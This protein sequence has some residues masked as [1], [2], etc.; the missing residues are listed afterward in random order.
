MATEWKEVKIGELGEVV[1]GATPST[2]NK[3]FYGGDIAWITPKDLSNYNE[4]YITRGERNITELG[5]QSCST[6][7]L[8]KNSILFSSRAPIGY[9]AIARN[10]MCTNQGFKSIIANADTDYL[11]LFYLLK[12]NKD[13]IE[14][15]GSGT[16]FKEVSTKVMQSIKLK[17]PCK[18]TQQKIAKILSSLDEKIELNNKMNENLHAQAQAIFKSWFVDFEPF[19]GTMPSDWEE[20]LLEEICTIQN[21][22][23]FKSNDY[24][25]DGCKMVRVT[26]INDCYLENEDYINLPCSFYDDEKYRQFQ[27][28]SFDI[29]LVM[30]G[31]TIGKIGIV[32]EKDLPCL[33]N[34]N[35]WRFR[36]KNNISQPYIYFTV[37]SIN[38]CVCGWSTGSARDFYRKDIFAKAKC[39]LPPCEVLEKFN[40]IQLNLFKKISN[41]LFENIKLAQIRDTLL[42][43]LMSG[44]LE[45]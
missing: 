32:T 28:K 18:Q 14:A 9:I 33:Q 13:K 21:G 17:V 6:R 38:K 34:Q 29:L 30:V 2:K 36:S 3:D 39:M 1:G 12:F 27:L 43:K 45:V 4:R 31:A 22:Y 23:A 44:E 7:L 41:N 26:N 10:E 15:M 24:C 40:Q 42:P 37:N 35:M 5:K 19:G 8:P 20:V 11:F 16:T 25:K